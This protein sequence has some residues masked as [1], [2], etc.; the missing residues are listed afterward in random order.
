MTP[1]DL[2]SEG[3]RL[4]RTGESRAVLNPQKYFG[5]LNLELVGGSE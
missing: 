3:G 2:A 1:L 5:R 4:D